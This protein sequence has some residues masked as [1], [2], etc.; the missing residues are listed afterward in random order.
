M[1]RGVGFL[2]GARAPLANDRDPFGVKRRDLSLTTG[3]QIRKL[4]LA[5]SLRSLGSDRSLGSGPWGQ[6]EFLGPWGQTEFQFNRSRVEEWRGGLGRCLCSLLV[7]PFVRG[8]HIISTCFVSTRRSSNRIRA[9]SG[10][11]TPGRPVPRSRISAEPFST[12]TAAGTGWRSGSVPIAVPQRASWRLRPSKPG[13]SHGFRAGRLMSTECSVRYCGVVPARSPSCTRPGWWT[14]PRERRTVRGLDFFLRRRSLVRH[15][16]RRV[17]ILREIG[18]P[19]RT[20]DY[21]DTL[22]A[23]ER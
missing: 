19:H 4:F 11:Q 13:P 17:Q 3:P 7:R 12:G 6:T 14:T 9:R 1:V 18:G 15:D 20:V 23:I 5:R 2:P 22:I 21:I 8:C 10:G 16:I